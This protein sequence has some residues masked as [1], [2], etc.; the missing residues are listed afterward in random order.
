MADSSITPEYSRQGGHEVSSGTTA[1]R[2]VHLGHD[3]R[4]NPTRES[5]ASPSSG[6]RKLPP[7]LLAVALLLVAGV[8]IARTLAPHFD[9][10]VAN[11]LTLIFGFF[12]WVAVVLAAATSASPRWVWRSLLGVP[13]ALVVLLAVLYRF[14]RVDAELV[15]KFTPRWQA[16]ALLPD[17]VKPAGDAERFA[18]APTDFPQFLGPNR[19]AVLASPTLATDWQTSPPE[20]LWKQPIGA[21]WSSFAVQGEAAV[22]MEQRDTEQWISAYDVE[23]G[24]LLWKTAVPGSHFNPLGGLGPRSTPTIHDNKVYAHTATGQL[25]CLDLISGQTLWQHD[26]LGLTGTTQAA[27]EKAVT[28]GRSGSPLIVDQRVIVPLGGAGP[29]AATLIAFQAADG[30]ELWRAGQDQISYASPLVATLNGVRQLLYTSEK[31]VAGYD[32]DSGAILWEHAWSSS[33]SGDANVS[34]P[35]PL[36]D[37]RVLLSKGYGRGA[38][39]ILVDQSADNSWTTQALWARTTVLKTK[40]TS[41][42][43]RDE[44]AYGL[45]DGILECVDMQTGKSVWKAGRYRH[46]QLLLVD[47]VLLISSEA[48]QVVLVAADPKAHR[49]LATQEVIGDPTWNAPTLSGNRL[50]MRNSDEAACV[51]LPL[52]SP[53]TAAATESLSRRTTPTKF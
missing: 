46:G 26:L 51:R 24:A 31:Q 23:S 18:P 47:D 41:C 52:Q 28:W 43:V 3:G 4:E 22:T 32:I 13:V 12:A 11:I 37:S 33:S 7:L 6:W 9:F 34:Q 50:L 25:L 5:S 49:V 10:A 30:T 16:A 36:D 20:I 2:E 27:A 35:V 53:T 8:A 19:N 39:V 15:P 42:V 29:Q 38:S 40:F 45:S 44:H 1:P 14:E 48:G 17:S 21:G